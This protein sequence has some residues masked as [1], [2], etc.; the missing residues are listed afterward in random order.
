MVI[1]GGARSG[2]GE[3]AL[4][5]L[6]ADTNESVTVRG[7][8]GVA[9]DDLRGALLEMAAVGAG[10]RTQRPL[11]HA[12]IN[13]ARDELMTDAQKARAV[14]RLADELGL[15]GQP[16][17]VV[18]HVKANREHLHVVWSR[19]DGETLKAIPDSHNYRRHELVARDLELEFS[20]QR[21]Q[22]AH[23]GRDGIDRPTRTPDPYEM[24][25]AARSSLSPAEATAE[26][27]GLWRSTDS[28]QAFVAAI[29]DAGWM[30]ARGD[31]RDFV[32][33]DPHGETH[34][35]ARRIDGVKARDVRDRLADIDPAGVPGVDQARAAL[36]D[37]QAERE[38]V[39][40]VEPVPDPRPDLVRDAPVEIHE[41]TPAPAMSPEERRRQWAAELRELAPRPAGAPEP[42]RDEG[43]GGPDIRR[44]DAPAPTPEPAQQARQ[45]AEHMLAEASRLRQVIDKARERLE[46]LGNRLETAFNRVRETFQ[47]KMPETNPKEDVKQIEIDAAEARKKEQREEAKKLAQELLQKWNSNANQSRGPTR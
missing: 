15:A 8:D 4:H 25:Q 39:A 3:L 30:L 18:E 34:S 6:R 17:V 21:V 36:R 38:R 12:S 5:L 35:L 20:H 45:A 19:I 9:A 33:I 24:M 26:L 37:R 27:T 46:A 43:S 22:G 28:G 13:T 11:Y 2:P 23:V 41:A 7:L 40:M 29:E 47:R 16:H 32:V 44:D 1:K 31:K 42:V 10:A 14:A